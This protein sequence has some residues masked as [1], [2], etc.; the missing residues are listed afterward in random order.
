MFADWVKIAAKAA[1]LVA[2]TALI[3]VVFSTI[4]IPS[5]DLSAASSYLNVAYSIAM[6]YIPG[7]GILWPIGL[8][9]LSLEMA[10]LVCKLALIAIK[11]V[12]K[13]NE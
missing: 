8:T 13:V 6:H 4:Q 10:L 11:W 3:I 2:G 5:L 9:L 12:L 1:A 7:F